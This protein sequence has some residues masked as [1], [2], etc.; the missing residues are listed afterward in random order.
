M[1]RVEA[2]SLKQ[3][4]VKIGHVNRISGLF[5]LALGVGLANHQTRPQSTTSDKTG[6]SCR[7]VIPSLQRID[8][9]CTTEF[10]NTQNE[11]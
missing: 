5:L 1:A 8:A 9:R 11:G 4:R 6:K 10:T 2:K 7:P 3:R